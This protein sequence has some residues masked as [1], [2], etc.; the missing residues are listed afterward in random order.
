MEDLVGAFDVSGIPKLGNH[1]YMGIVIGTKPNIKSIIKSMGHKKIH[2]SNIMTKDHDAII[3]KLKF[4]NRQNIAFCI[5][6]NRDQIIRN[7]KKLSKIKH[8]NI[9]NGKIYRTYDYLLFQELREMILGFLIKHKYG[10]SDII[11]ECDSDCI[12]FVKSSGLKPTNAGDAHMLADI[13]AW[14]NNR[15]I[16]PD[17]VITLDLAKVIEPK[18]MKV[19]DK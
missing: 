3:S 15:S 19:L 14:A 1:R 7:V 10:L 9:S 12:R 4:D 2:M 18:M 8:K 11:F 13:V 17:G 16:E 5:R 6:I